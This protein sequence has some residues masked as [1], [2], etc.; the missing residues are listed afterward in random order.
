VA[1]AGNAIFPIAFLAMLSCVS[2]AS[3][4]ETAQIYTRGQWLPAEPVHETARPENRA[5][6]FLRDNASLVQLNRATESFHL[7]EIVNGPALET[8]RLEKRWRGL[9]V[10]GGE[11]LVHFVHGKS[12]FALADSTP[13]DSLSP[14]PRIRPQNARELAVGAHEGTARNTGQAEL[15]VLLLGHGESRRAELAY[16]V[17]VEDANPLQ[18]ET[19]HLSAENGATLLVAPAAVNALARKVY[20]ALG[21][22]EDFAV[23]AEDKTQERW[24]LL[25]S[26]PPPAP[27]PPADPRVLQSG[28]LAWDNSGL[29][30]K[31]YFERH[32]RDSIDGRGLEIR[33]A[34][35]FGGVNFQ[36][37][38]WLNNRLIMLYGLA[39]AGGQITD[40]AS[41]LD[42]VGHELT[43]GV[44]A[45]T[46]NLHTYEEAGALNESF[47]D[48]FGKLIAFYSGR[49]LD[50]KMGT[51][52]FRDGKSSLRDL[53]N[54]EV[55]KMQDFRYRG[56][57][58]E[59]NNDFCG[60]HVNSGIPSKAAVL[61]AQKAGTENA[62]KIYYLTLT[63]LLR[64]GSDFLEAS[65]Q[66]EKACTVLFGEGS[67]DC[68]AVRDA[69]A[70]VGL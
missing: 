69:F 37:A 7:K 70:F 65:S 47:S 41:S 59:R 48:F 26:E 45:A 61:I 40:Y 11:A 46:A 50:W 9:R 34:V 55:G 33:S 39:P 18:T 1:W 67:P 14:T 12:L 21:T 35:N 62:G 10:Q 20:S 66:T 25:L 53:D 6:N 52:L 28:R 49:P 30:Y 60:V 57:I 32:Q 58:C 5:L 63:Q 31:Y 3:G 29:V 51:E 27:S 38:A 23:V 22:Q 16:A 15:E 19:V 44:T 13:L 42:I 8:H 4:Q 68:V 54:P 64:P 36:N 17:L 43:H 24:P 2:G 56:Q